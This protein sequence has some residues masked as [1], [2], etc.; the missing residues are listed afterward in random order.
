M[1][2]WIIAI[3]SGITSCLTCYGMSW[4]GHNPLICMAVGVWAGLTVASII[5][6]F[7]R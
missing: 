4:L 2:K 3:A 7:W 6:C 5:R 1:S